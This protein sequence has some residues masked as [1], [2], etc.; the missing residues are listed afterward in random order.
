[1]TRRALPFGKAVLFAVLAFVG[2]YGGMVFQGI[3]DS[4]S[5]AIAPPALGI[6][7]VLYLVTTRVVGA[8]DSVGSPAANA[9]IRI[10]GAGTLAALA[11][12]ATRL[13]V[14]ERGAG[15]EPQRFTRSLLAGL[16]IAALASLGAA[17]WS[18]RAEAM[19]G[20][21]VRFAARM[22]V[23][24]ALGMGLA[25]L[26]SPK[27]DRDGYLETL[28][29]V[30]GPP[31][32]TA[33]RLVT[34]A[35]ELERR[36]RPRDCTV[37]LRLGD[38]TTSAI[39][40][41]DARSVV[42]RR[43]EVRDLWIL[44]GGGSQLFQADGRAARAAFRGDTLERVAVRDRGMRAPRGWAI[45]ALLG[46]ALASFQILARRHPLRRLEEIA[47]AEEATVDEAGLVALASGGAPL[48]PAQ[49]V[50]AGPALVIRP[51]PGPGGA[52]R[53]AVGAERVVPGT[54]AENEAQEREALAA[55]DARALLFVLTCLSPLA[56]AWILGVSW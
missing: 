13:P 9:L 32:C 30:L 50:K 51:Q 46:A 48:R 22:L 27:P 6:A 34:G 35:L 10:A 23:P 15:A 12:V 19:G 7:A 5:A 18:Q 24:I 41:K 36:C 37:S 25:T 29:V 28:P 14:I 3:L 40:V 55:C 33:P 54:R 20:A 47:S 31:G 8:R 11:L 44:D 53:Q 38:R 45:L 16:A 52:Y 43:D 2:C 39:T 21:P 26:A 56:T 1:M 4:L 17:L 49:A 42:V